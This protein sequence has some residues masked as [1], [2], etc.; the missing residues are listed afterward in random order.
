M[1]PETDTKIT[2][3][4]GLVCIWACVYNMIFGDIPYLALFM[5]LLVG[6]SLHLTDIKI[7]KLENEI[8]LLKLRR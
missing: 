4:T 1:N 7:T 6:C 2:A 8:K 5:S 3:I